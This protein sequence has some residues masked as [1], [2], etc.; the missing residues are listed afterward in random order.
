MSVKTFTKTEEDAKS[1]SS[2]LD[3]FTQE[4]SDDFEQTMGREQSNKKNYDESS[5]YKVDA[6]AQ[7]SW[8]WGSAGVSG[9]LTGGTTSAREEFSKNISNALQKHSAKASAKR[10]VKIETSYEVKT[11]T[12]EETS[13]ERTIENINVSR[14][15]NFVFRQM[16][17][18]FISLLHLVDV[19]IGYFKVLQVQGQ[20]NPQFV[21]REATLPQLDALLEDVI[22]PEKRAEVRADIVRQLSN[23]FDYQDRHHRFVEEKSLNDR[24]NKIV[25]LSQYLRVRKDYT[26]TYLDEATGSQ[27]TVPG[28]SGCEQIGVA[29]RG[30]IAEALLGQAT[31]RQL[32]AWSSGRSRRGT[33]AG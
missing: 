13:V 28:S 5:Q 11:S 1:A 6:T 16:N 18:E 32:F 24:E 30:V 15:L 31:P 26:S 29:H 12:G 27:F 20:P 7:A 21:Y 9:G 10:D 3:S 23:I 17:Q 22:V 33:A 25:P 14:T 19:R 4:S 2:I 8:G